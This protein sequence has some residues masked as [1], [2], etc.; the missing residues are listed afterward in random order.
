MQLAIRKI[1]YGSFERKALRY[2]NIITEQDLNKI[3]TSSSQQPCSNTIVGSNFHFKGRK[4]AKK[5]WKDVLS[6]KW[7]HPTPSFTILNNSM[8]I[9][10][11]GTAIW[12][13][14]VVLPTVYNSLGY[15]LNRVEK[16][17]IVFHKLLIKSRT[18]EHGIS[19]AGRLNDN[20][21]HWVTEALPLLQ[22]IPHDKHN[23]YKV[24][25]NKSAPSFVMEYLKLFGINE[26]QV[27]KLKPKRKI[28]IKNLLIGSLPFR[29][30][31]NNSPLWATH[32]YDPLSYKFVRD[33]ALSS[34]SIASNG[35]TNIYIS[36]EDAMSRKVDNEDEV[37][38]LLQQFGYV[39]VLLSSLSVGDQI[40]LFSSAKNLVTPHGAGLT[41]MIFSSAI[42]IIEF[43]PEQ[44]SIMP[45]LYFCQISEFAKNYH[46][47]LL[48]ASNEKDNMT[49]NI[50]Q[51]TSIL[52]NE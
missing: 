34:L 39:K 9:G 16:R 50:S 47:V 36:R 15:L 46:Q 14:K 8:L 44:L 29:R 43:Y 37:F 13:G 22:Y 51:L 23:S 12:K 11:Y 26:D 49:V 27:V 42:K 28:K 19:L 10:E 31:I 17:Q 24:F 1:L 6:K 20:Y 41:N 30:H 18:Y 5:E 3:S 40:A 32:I 52:N 38:Q 4:D 45:N 48:C 21:Y 25:V 7:L 2:D 33:K 35:E